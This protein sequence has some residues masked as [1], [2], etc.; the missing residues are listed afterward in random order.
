MSLFFLVK[1]LTD[2]SLRL[3]S[4]SHMG[5][6]RTYN[7]GSFTLGMYAKYSYTA[8]TYRVS[9]Y[10]KVMLPLTFY[11][12]PDFTKKKVWLLKWPL[13][14]ILSLCER[15]TTFM[16]FYNGYFSPW[17]SATG[18]LELK[19]SSLSISR[20]KSEGSSIADADVME[21]SVRL[22]Q[23]PGH[24]ISVLAKLRNEQLCTDF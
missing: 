22:S 20:W 10:C 7:Y 12:W 24:D 5:I 11:I 13:P 21:W 9:H 3:H 15:S 14:L 6:I 8:W 17:M 19:V 2:C 18:L 1:D 4:C 16:I 23:I